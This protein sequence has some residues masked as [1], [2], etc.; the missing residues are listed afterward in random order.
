[1]KKSPQ[2][3]W[4]YSGFLSIGIAFIT[5]FAHP[6]W[7][8]PLFNEIGPLKDKQLERSILDLA[9][10]AG[11]HDGRVFEVDKSKD[12]TMGN[13]YVAGLGSTKR[14]VIWDT[15]I[16]ANSKEGIL[17]IMGHEMGHYV[18]HH[19]WWWLACFSFFAFAILYLIYK[20]TN[21]LLPHYR[22]RLGFHYLYDIAS[23]PLLLFLIWL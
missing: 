8:D 20:A 22:K 14:I 1:M 9:A 19:A 6:I 11:I 23:L 16:Q 17:F 4:V 21:F 10:R 5:T 18:L 3:W 7:I 15:S 2:R 12:T 13:A